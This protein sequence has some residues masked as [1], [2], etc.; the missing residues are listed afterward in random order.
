MLGFE[1]RDRREADGDV[2]EQLGVDAAQPGERNGAEASV[3]ADAEDQLD[4]VR[5]VCRPL[6][7]VACRRES[8][9]HISQQLLEGRRV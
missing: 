5:E 4:A 9:C 8:C 7:G 3:A 2:P 1:G 6:D